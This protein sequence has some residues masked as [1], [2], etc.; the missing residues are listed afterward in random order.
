[1]RLKA[2]HRR[3]LPLLQ[4]NMKLLATIATTAALAFVSL[5]V[6]AQDRCPTSKIQLEKFRVEN[7]GTL[8][9]SAYGVLVNTC[10]VPAGVQLKIVFT[11]AT[12]KI[13]R[14]E[15]PWPA[16]ISNIPSK[17]D[18]PFQMRFP[19]VEGF[20]KVDVRITRTKTW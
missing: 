1:M 3:P 7:E 19:R 11:D 14:V 20:D 5:G 16:S 6:V 10:E 13:L 8:T 17:S 2:R 4:T 15:D 9:T 12:G 18:F